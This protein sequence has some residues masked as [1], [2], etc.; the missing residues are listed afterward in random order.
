MDLNKSFKS[1]S[2][3]EIEIKDEND[4]LL[5]LH[6]LVDRPIANKSFTIFTPMQ[7][8]SYYPVRVGSNVKITFL[9]QESE[10]SSK[11]PYTFSAVITDRA[12]ESDLSILTLK[13]I[14]PAEKSQRRK[15]FRLSYVENL[16]YV[17]K[18]QFYAMLTKDISS[19]GLKALV[20][21]PIAVGDRITT[22]L[23][24]GDESLKLQTE[25]IYSEKL[26]DSIKKIEIRG[27]FVDVDSNTRKKITR[28]LLEKQSEEVRK[29]LDDKGYSKLYK[30]VNGDEFHNRRRKKDF[31][32]R[33]VEY[34]S[35]LSWINFI[36]IAGIFLQARP[37]QSYGVERFFSIV[38]GS[39]WNVSLLNIFIVFSIA[40]LCI[41][42][43]G[44]LLN[45][46]RM[47][48]EGDKYNKGLMFNLIVAILSISAYTYIINIVI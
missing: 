33:M 39:V 44:L 28:Y 1:G 38:I 17:Y 41:C 30:L 43:Y 23:D 26:S 12:S 18:D 34:L 13:M 32:I 19:T 48:R 37:R 5:D 2:R 42:L 7:N 4:N 16:E 15:S 29:S 46:T 10:S 36:F 22:V 20:E 14:G 8:G 47:K 21:L 45:S 3:I 11:T 25:I 27:N 35:L 24:I 6:T 40:Q 9:H 31:N